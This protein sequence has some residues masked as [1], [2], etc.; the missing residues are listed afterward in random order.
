MLC[1]AEGLFDME[2]NED[3]L[4]K[5]PTF[6]FIYEDEILPEI[7]IQELISLDDM[8]KEN[9]YFVA[10]TYEDIVVYASQLLKSKIGST[11]A[12]RRAIIYA[13][14][15]RSIVYP[16][17]TDLT[18][19]VYINTDTKRIDRSS[20]NLT[21]DPKKDKPPD[22]VLFEQSYKNALKAPYYNLQ[23]SELNKLATPFETEDPSENDSKLTINKP[24]N[25]VL[26]IESNDISK[27]TSTDNVALPIE[28]IAWVPPQYTSPAYV[29]DEPLITKT[30]DIKYTSWTSAGDKSLT[31]DEW[32]ETRIKPGFL[33]TLKRIENLTTRQGIEL[34][35]SYDGI[36]VDSL[37]VSQFDDLVKH[38]ESLSDDK[39]AKGED[40]K[41]ENDSDAYKKTV[42]P[43]N[44][45]QH[46]KS[47][48]DIL[49]ASKPV[50]VTDD[51]L[52][53]IEQLREAC[54]NYIMQ[55][56]YNNGQNNVQNEVI[57]PYMLA[58]SLLNNSLTIEDVTTIV[59]TYTEQVQIARLK[60]FIDGM[61]KPL[62]LEDEQSKPVTHEQLANILKRSA[63]SII[64]EGAR[65]KGKPN[66]FLGTFREIAEIVAGNDTSLYD[67]KPTAVPEMIFEEQENMILYERNDYE[68]GED[69]GINKEDEMAEQD[70]I[71]SFPDVYD[72]MFPSLEE[73]NDGVKEVLLTVLPQLLKIRDA[74]GLP[75]ESADINAWIKNL[76]QFA[77]GRQSRAQQLKTQVNEVSTLVARQLCASSMEATLYKIKQMANTTLSGKLAAVYPQIHSEWEK[78]CYHTMVSALSEFWMECLERSLKGTLDFS[79]LK[80]MISL[81]GVWSPYG[82]PLEDD[83]KVGRTG[84]MVYICEVA[85]AVHE[86]K[87]HTRKPTHEDM[88]KYVHD[89]HKDRILK[90]RDMWQKIKDQPQVM[91]KAELAKV[92][93]VA[94]IKNLKADRG[95]VNNVVATYVNA[96][97]YLPNLLPKSDAEKYKKQAAWGLGCC[98]AHL[99][100]EY[101]ADV[102]WKGHVNALWKIKQSLAKDR[103][104][105][106][107]RK[108]YA[109]FV[110]TKR[111]SAATKQNDA[112]TKTCDFVQVHDIMMRRRDVERGEAA[113]DV[114]EDTTL[115]ILNNVWIP[116]EDAATLRS[117]PTQ[118]S[119]LIGNI[120]SALC[121]SKQAV[122]ISSVLDSITSYDG[123]MTFLSKICLNLRNISLGIAKQD[124]RRNNNAN[125]EL[126]I[127]RNAI[128]TVKR[129]K[130]VITTAMNDA[131]SPTYNIKKLMH[132]AT[133]TLAIA[134]CSPGVVQRINQNINIDVPIGLSANVI[135]SITQQHVNTCNTWKITHYILTATEIQ[136]YINKVREEAKL[137]L[138]AKYD[139]LNVEDRQLLKD[140]KRFKLK[141][142]EGGDADAMEGVADADA[143]AGVNVGGDAEADADAQ[144]ERQ[145][146]AE[147]E[148]ESYDAD[149]NDEYI[150]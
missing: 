86:S 76:S 60:I 99:D 84:I 82:A 17:K 111:R 109:T 147:Y 56:R 118:S 62:L 102:D 23:Q 117:D 101:E 50:I 13:N 116:K 51:Y 137:K 46:Y 39:E 98:T 92:S 18:K 79:I 57:H 58:L 55:S 67:G 15:H 112:P 110:N 74:S 113:N 49:T 7:E 126:A 41:E 127:M 136:E 143:M 150:D 135:P 90:L 68:G 103:W 24:S 107:P 141:V 11:A 100:N 33:R 120:L 22:S 129:M 54:A 35:L 81:V 149:K 10:M 78:A 70:A 73:C 63:D 145:G 108:T 36:S 94:M 3:N 59:K 25:I 125:Q 43:F 75:W 14:L 122:A 144:Y 83:V 65:L 95:A 28:S 146:E 80:G 20:I 77:I 9:P 21:Q 123:V 71:D 105:T 89:E 12:E 31:L 32:I 40:N 106:K 69:D 16:D 26:K 5:S 140:M 6:D 44:I 61:P 148:M 97:V 53:N 66:Q 104:I 72:E 85:K 138:L 88:M 128:E 19:Y 87:K 30:S 2:H 48:I 114:P 29:F 42:K 91:T 47:F 121:T 119:K 45:E 64:D 139:V 124:D 38:L 52:R 8:M 96:F 133:Y 37:T 34:S 132:Y 130:R 142:E 4:E 93:L 115:A 27:I 131:T 134:L 1:L